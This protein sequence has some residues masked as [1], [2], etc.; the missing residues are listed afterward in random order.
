M[1]LKYLILVIS[2]F[3]NFFPIANA[4]EESE[5]FPANIGLSMNVLGPIFGIYSL[6]VTTFVTSRM[7]IGLDGVYYSTRDFDPKVEGWQAKIRMN[8]FFHH[9]IKV[10]FI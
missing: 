5:V 10:V 6:G 4:Q 9:F 3:F 1:K 7:Q 2:I 8:Y